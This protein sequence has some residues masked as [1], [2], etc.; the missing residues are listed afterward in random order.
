[1]SKTYKVIRLAG[2]SDKSHDEAV[3]NALD[4]AHHS[5]KGLNW[6]EVKEQRGR[7]DEK[8]GRVVEWQVVMDV[9]FKIERH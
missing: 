2:T 3:Q 8:S 6:F 9:G 4:D 1:M 7:I 5:L